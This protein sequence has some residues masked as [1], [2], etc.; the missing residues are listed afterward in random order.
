M[1]EPWDHDGPWSLTEMREAIDR[2]RLSDLELEMFHES[3]IP[4]PTEA[5]LC[6]MLEQVLL[7]PVHGPGEED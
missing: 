7:G 6:E 3:A 2:V 4:C 1:S 5:L